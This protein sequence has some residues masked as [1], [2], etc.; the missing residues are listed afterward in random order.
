MKRKAP[1]HGKKESADMQ[2]GTAAEYGSPEKRAEKRLERTEAKPSDRIVELRKKIR[3]GFYNSKEVLLEIVN[4]L[5]KDIKEP[6]E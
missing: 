1:L 2:T 4:K 3:S 5:V 6:K